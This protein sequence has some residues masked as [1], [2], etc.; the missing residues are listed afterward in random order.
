ME[1]DVIQILPYYPPHPGGL[2]THAQQRGVHWV[3]QEHGRVC[4]LIWSHSQAA[5]LDSLDDRSLIKTPDGSVIGY[6]EQQIDHLILPTREL[7]PW[8]PVPKVWTR[9]YRQVLSWLQHWRKRETVV[10]TR[11]RFFLTSLLGG[12]LAKRR[13]LPRVHIEHGS[14]SVSLGLWRKDRAA[15][16]YDQLVGR[17]IFR[18][19]DLVVPISQA[20]DRFVRKF[21]RRHVGE[22]IYRGIDID[23]EAVEQ[24]DVEDLQE[25]FP[26]KVIIWYVGRIY[27]R[28]N[29]DGLI[30]ARYELPQELR[31][32]SQLVVVGDGD[33]LS[34][35]EQADRDGQ[36]YFVGSKPFVEALAYQRQFAIHAHSSHPGG[37]I[38]SS[39]LQA[40]ALG[41]MIVATPYEWAD[42]VISLD[43]KHG[44]LVPDA[45]VWSLRE[46]LVEALARRGDY[47]AVATANEQLIAEQFTWSV[48][49]GRYYT[50][51]RKIIWE[52][53]EHA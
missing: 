35:V 26:G 11:T 5:K 45:S 42:E 49:I 36:V 12:F 46:G 10:V 14:A 29:V 15:W 53:Y 34:Q 41:C 31:E 40:M 28:K 52:S 8:F 25:R 20:C 2:E 47:A 1:I 13:K 33:Y 16:V 23:T 30:D 38:S 48:S 21:T 32:Q 18:A 37:G 51:F 6:R 4:Q 43:G 27:Q 7:I 3:S 24:A 19:A 22:V 39:L 17:W 9:Q 50:A 44:V